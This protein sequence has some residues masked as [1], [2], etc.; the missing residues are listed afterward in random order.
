MAFSDLADFTVSRESVRFSQVGFGVPLLL[1]YHTNFGTRSKVYAGDILAGLVA[2]GFANGDS[3]YEKAQLML[4]QNP[5]PGR[6]VVGRVDTAPTKTVDFT[7][8]NTTAGFVY[9]FECT[10][11]ATVETASYTVQ[12]LD[13][14][15]DICA[16]ITTAVN[17]LTVFGANVTATDN[18]TKVTVAADTAG[19]SFQIG[20]YAAPAD[21]AVEDV[22]TD[23]GLETDLAEIEA[24]NSDWYCV[25]SEYG[26]KAC[27]DAISAYVESEERVAVCA[28]PNTNV[29]D[30]GVSN[31][32]ASG[33]L[34]LEAGRTMLWW[35]NTVRGF[36][37]VASAGTMLP[38][39]PG[40]STWSHKTLRGVLASRL[41]G[42]QE[43]ALKDKRCNWY[44]DH[45]RLLRL[46]FNGIMPDG[47]YMDEVRGLDWA[48]VQYQDAVVQY[49]AQNGKVPYTAAGIGSIKTLLEGV[50]QRI[51]SAGVFSP[52]TPDSETDVV[53]FI[54]TPDITD[55]PLAD[56]QSRTLNNVTV[57]ASLAGA[58][59]KVVGKI[60]ITN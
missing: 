25:I 57:T 24:E 32:V 60:V 43:Q 12:A 31:D 52:G 37:H 21:L 42:S 34:A 22:T 5:S 35:D 48:K 20:G 56:K 27:I 13:T 28:T 6:I 49:L 9:S 33:L 36:V 18:L 11:G 14:V 40:G 16:G 58:I 29:V 4:R 55:V 7:P 38:R 1:G 19:D 17:G 23:P 2:D 15:A 53:P 10:Y 26:S 44:A 51:V 59:H 8:S 30:G 39:A 46:T 45:G 3:I 47:S 50:T 54:T 41:N